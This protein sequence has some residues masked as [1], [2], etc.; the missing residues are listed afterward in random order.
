MWIIPAIDLKDGRCVRLK[1]GR[2]QDET[3]YSDDPVAVARRW[4]DAGAEWLHVVDL[5]AAIEGRS[6]NQDCI[7][8]IVGSAGIPV[9]VGGGLRTPADVDACLS[10]GAR[11]AI[12]GTAAT[13]DLGV[14]QDLCRRH[15]GRIAVGI[16]ARYGRVATHGWT[17]TSDITAVDL[18]R[19]VERAGVA[20]IIFTDIHRD[21]MQSG[22]NIE[23]TRKLAESVNLPVIASGGVGSIDHIR[24]LLPLEAVGVVGVITGKALYSGAIEYAEARAVAGGRSGPTA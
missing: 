2:M 21:G 24:A 14:L 15:P 7:G 9:Q 18:A 4:V 19:R 10:L 5:D 17:R 13:G 8:R 23:E 16:D 11:R 3:I 1:Q 12:I 6:R 22:P 20:A